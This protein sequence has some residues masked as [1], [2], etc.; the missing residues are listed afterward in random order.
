M[1]FNWD[2]W[3]IFNF[4]GQVNLTECACSNACSELVYESRV[5]YSKFPD[6]SLIEIVHNL[7]NFNHSPDYM[8]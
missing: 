3:F 1:Y 2:N 6:D 5:S 4:L 7:L 8:R